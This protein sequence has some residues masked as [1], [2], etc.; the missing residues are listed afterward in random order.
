MVFYKMD[1]PGL[2]LFETSVVG[3]RGLIQ[4]SWIKKLLLHKN[5]VLTPYFMLYNNDLPLVICLSTVS[6]YTNH[7]R[8]SHHA[9]ILSP[10]LNGTEQQHY[11]VGN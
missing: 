7:T 8:L 4:R 10:K 9:F 2:K 5:H 6:M 11:A 1:C 3:L